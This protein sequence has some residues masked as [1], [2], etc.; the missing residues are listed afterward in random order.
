[1]HF[2]FD[3]GRRNAVVVAGLLVCL[4]PF[5]VT[6]MSSIMQASTS[7]FFPLPLSSTPVRRR[8]RL[9]LESRSRG[10]HLFQM[11]SPMV[12]DPAP[13]ASDSSSVEE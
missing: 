2:S 5:V 1:M 10:T 9:Y 11:E 12:T 8:L 13:P 7:A 4:T 6:R 3:F